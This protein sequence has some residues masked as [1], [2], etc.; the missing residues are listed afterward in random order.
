MTCCSRLSAVLAV[1]SLLPACV[2]AMDIFAYAVADTK[3]GEVA[4][5]S[6]V[7]GCV[8]DLNLIYSQIGVPFALA[9]YAVVTNDAFYRVVYTNAHTWTALCDFTNNTGGVELY[10]V[11]EI[12][13]PAAAFYTKKGIVVGPEATPRTVSHEIGHAFGWKDIYVNHGGT[14]L[15]VE[16]RPSKERMPVEWSP[17]Y[18]R[19][20]TQADL[21]QKLLM[22]GR[23]SETKADIPGGDIYGLWYVNRKDASTGRWVR[24]WR[25]SLAPVG[26]F[27]ESTHLTLSE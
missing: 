2:C 12:D 14:A 9:S 16:G 15:A 17:F 19:G 4:S 3:A 10:F 7:A 27:V 24:D 11:G 23:P 5:V 21:V 20:T 6:K 8:S 25:L 18:P 13:G 26:A 22:Y 1:A